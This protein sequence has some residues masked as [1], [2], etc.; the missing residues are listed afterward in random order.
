MRIFFT[1]NAL[2]EYKWFTENEIRIAE[3]INHIISSIKEDPFNGIGK[4]EPLKYKYASF[5]SRRIDKSNR[6]IYQVL[7]DNRIIIHQCKGH[8]YDK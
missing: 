7:K 1:D 5:W 2:D 3:R 4:P 8:Y 6:L